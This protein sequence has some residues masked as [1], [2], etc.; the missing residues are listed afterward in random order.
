MK[1]NLIILSGSPRGG[2]ITWKK[3]VEN[4]MKP[5]DADLALSYGNS[6][7][8]PKYLSKIAKYNW[9]F[10]EPENWRHYLTK[11]YSDELPKFFIKG[12]ENGLAGIDGLKGSGAIVFSLIDI[13][14]Q[15]HLENL[16][17]Y[18]HLIYTRF[19]QYYFIPYDTPLDNTIHIPEGEDYFGIND[20]FIVLPNKAIKDF[21]SICQFIETDYSKKD[22]E[23]LNTNSVF[24]EHI[25]HLSKEFE[26]IRTNRTMATVATDNDHTRWREAEVNF[27]LRKDLK[28]KYPGEFMQSLKYLIESP[29]PFKVYIQN[30]PSILQ[31]FYLSMRIK[32]GPYKKKYLKK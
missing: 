25:K 17:Q 20:R 22:Y 14:Y 9:V 7:P 10:E 29:K 1:K 4:L 19:D 24:N 21:F 5:L 16:L 11:Y 26:V 6:F 32:L 13:L 23:F 8:P 12:K 30:I 3:M 28:L 27:F 15:N 31:Y 2:E 18:D